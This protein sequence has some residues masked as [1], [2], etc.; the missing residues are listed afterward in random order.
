MAGTC[1]EKIRHDDP[2]CGK[3][4]LQVFL[5][6]DGT[7]NGYCFSCGKYEADPYKDQPRGY[8][9]Q[10]VKKTQEQIEAEIKEIRDEY[11]IVALPDRKLRADSLAYFGIKIG[12]SEEDGQ[13]PASHFYPYYRDGALVGY[14]CRIIEGKRM[15]SLGDC[16]DVDLFGWEQA[17]AAGGKKLYITEG[18]IDAVSLYQALRD[19][20]KGT[21]YENLHPPVVSLPHGAGAAG[22]DLARLAKTVGKTFKEIVFVFDMDDAGRRAVEAG[23][24]I[25]PN[26]VSATLPG[27]DFNQCVMDGRQIAAVNAVVF[28]A[29]RPKNSRLIQASS[30]REAAKAPPVFGVSWP[31]KHI[32]E[33][34]RGIRLGE[35]IY[36]GAGQKQGKSEVVNQVAAHLMKEHGW[37]VFLCKPEEANNKTF[38][39]IAGKMVGK[40]FHDPTKAF[41]EVAYD[42]AADLIGD[43]LFLMNLYQHVDFD[44]LKADIIEAVK[45]H[46]VKAV[47][48]DPIT[49]FTNGMAAAEANTKLQ[50]IAQELAAMA[51]DLGIV[52]FIFCH[53]RNP[54][55]GPSHERGGDVL[56]SQ[57][58]G[59]RAMARSCNLMLGLQGNR[60][61]DLP[62][63][64]RNMRNLVLL[65][66]REFGNTG[67]YGLYWD[68][69]T[70]IFNEV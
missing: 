31:W 61:P 49:N 58:A 2:R 22:K 17:V 43:R 59:S 16:G 40:F 7:Y 18:E 70:G 6:D 46:D 19:K 60:D 54:D 35:T 39:M 41:D 10:V 44:V 26:A 64:E 62:P 4:A 55:G 66:D 69:N 13:T 36:I 9:P 48:I 24:L 57:F 68:L 65:E 33:A 32:T 23:M 25:F 38:K 12:V 5:A 15:W 50:E 45:V 47:F 8:K 67:R 37:N 51:L 29:S 11:P 1:V 3:H 27:K 34:T 20:A 28:G 63:E 53:L 42:R 14:K 30:L 21:Q 56:S 52:I